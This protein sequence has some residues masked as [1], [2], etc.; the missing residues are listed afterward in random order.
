MRAEEGVLVLCAV[1]F[2]DDGTGILLSHMSSGTI[3]W[4]Y[5]R[6]ANNSFVTV[7]ML[8]VLSTNEIIASCRLPDGIHILVLNSTGELGC[9]F[10]PIA[11]LIKYD[12]CLTGCCCGSVISGLLIRDELVWNGT[13]GLTSGLGRVVSTA[14]RTRRDVYLT[15]RDGVF[16]VSE[17]IVAKYELYTSGVQQQAAISWVLII[18]VIFV[19]IGSYGS[20]IV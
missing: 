19:S 7:D 15:L 18:S 8:S 12:W 2:I 11:L 9:L 10:F 16:P 13:T 4:V 3:E 20:S 14:G 5:S 1:K 17:A 6:A